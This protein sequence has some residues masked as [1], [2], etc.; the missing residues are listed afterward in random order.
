VEDK[1]AVQGRAFRQEE[2]Q[3]ILSLLAETDMTISE[4]AARMR[5]SRSAVIAANRKWKVRAYYGLKST[6][7]R[8]ASDCLVSVQKDKS[9]AA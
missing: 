2:I 3:R 9:A 4:I 8:A 1:M 5:C 6:W 7:Q